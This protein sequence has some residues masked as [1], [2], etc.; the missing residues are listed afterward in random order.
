MKPP[1]KIR[2]IISIL[3][4]PLVLIYVMLAGAVVEAYNLFKIFP[5]AIKDTWNI[6]K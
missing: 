6:K 4:F 1:P 5:K 3:L 2:C